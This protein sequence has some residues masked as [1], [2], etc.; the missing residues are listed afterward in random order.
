MATKIPADGEVQVVAASSINAVLESELPRPVIA[1]VP[2]PDKWN[3]YGRQY[4]ATMYTLAVEGPPEKGFIRLMFEG[5]TSTERALKQF[6]GERDIRPISEVSVAFVSLIPNVD[7]YRVLVSEIGFGPAV[8]ALRALGDAVVENIEQTNP[9]RL[10]LIRS[11]DF[12]LGIIR[13]SGAYEALLRGA[14]HL[15]PDPIAATDDSAKEFAFAAKLPNAENEYK[16]SFDFLPD[17]IFGDRASVLIGKNGSGKSQFINALISSLGNAPEEPLLASFDEKPAFSRVLM[18]S[19]VPDDLFPRE[20]GA[21][22]GIDYEHFPI[23]S[24]DPLRIDGALSSLAICISDTSSIFPDDDERAT[25]RIGLVKEALGEIGLWE[26]LH[27]PLEPTEGEEED[28]PHVV[29]V[30]G[31]AFFPIKRHR[32]NEQNGLKL[33][34]RLAWKGSPVVLTASQKVRRLSS[35]EVA[36]I[37]LAAQISAS[38]QPG[39][40]LLLDEPETH[41]HPNYISQAMVLLQTVLEATRSI[42]IIA[43]HSAYVVREVPRDKV[44]IFDLEDEHIE[45]RK[46]RMQTFGASIDAISQFVFGDLEVDHRYQDSLEK[47]ALKTG[48]DIGIDAVVRDF[49]GALNP[50]SLSFIADVIKQAD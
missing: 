46:P 29:Q 27:L 2:D 20:I 42:A 16:V 15:R 6:L 37:R 22:R 40:L 43:T 21:W 11:E 34:H 31:L 9:D 45:I 17:P 44:R 19:S 41:L 48:R 5:Q 30:D 12:Y 4:F 38:V 50:E 3:D 8:S 26:G 23:S 36:M 24:H 18:F 49:G 28:L 33:L 25:R 39:S 1:I 32:M 35:G 10:R 13:Q 47:W 7:D 14:R